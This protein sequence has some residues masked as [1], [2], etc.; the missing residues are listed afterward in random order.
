MAESLPLAEGPEA[1]SPS[2]AASEETLNSQGSSFKYNLPAG[3]N[4]TCR[5]SVWFLFHHPS[6]RCHKSSGVGQDTNLVEKERF[7][8]CKKQRREDLLERICLSG[9]PLVRSG[10]IVF[11]GFRI[12]L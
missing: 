1:C 2:V 3:G 7:D 8:Y 11:A 10:Q 9:Q 6:F 4:T 5:L 12:L